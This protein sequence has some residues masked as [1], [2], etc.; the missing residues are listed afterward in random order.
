V[1]PCFVFIKKGN[2]FWFRNTTFKHDSL[3]GWLDDALHDL[4]YLTGKIAWDCMPKIVR[5]FWELRGNSTEYLSQCPLSKGSKKKQ[6]VLDM[7]EAFDM[8]HESWFSAVEEK[9]M[10]FH[11]DSLMD[12]Q[13]K[14]R[15]SINPQT[16][17][18]WNYKYI[19]PNP[20]WPG[21]Q[22][23]PYLSEK[24]L[25]DIHIETALAP[26]KDYVI[27]DD[28]N[29]K[30]IR[31][32]FEGET[33]EDTKPVV[34]QYDIKEFG[35][36]GDL[37]LDGLSDV[38]ASGINLD[39]LSKEALALQAE[40]LARVGA[41]S[42]EVEGIVHGLEKGDVKAQHRPAAARRDPLPEMKETKKV[43]KKFNATT[44]GAPGSVQDQIFDYLDEMLQKNVLANETTEGEDETDG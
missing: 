10:I 23:L 35:N 18:T 22:K 28:K 2:Y 31:V 9:G 43:V 41:Y 34:P 25:K 3:S 32:F 27:V 13:N 5:W 29:S 14:F 40:E 20:D 42:K 36:I 7:G 4:S 16:A 15:K 21:W 26:L 33:E 12:F 1:F 38:D 8:W 24:G 17:K 30:S 44:Q 11:L 39:A 37:S 19:I 6:N